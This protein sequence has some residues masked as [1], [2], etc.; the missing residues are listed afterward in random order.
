MVIW[1]ERKDAYK[2]TTKSWV[3]QS[4][5]LPDRVSL[6]KSVIDLKLLQIPHCKHTVNAI[7]KKATEKIQRTINQL[8]LL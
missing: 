6:N 7:N 5:H 8:I 2:V 3:E 1:V 4:L